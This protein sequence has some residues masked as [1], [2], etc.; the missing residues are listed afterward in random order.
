MGEIESLKP[1][2]YERVRASLPILTVWALSLVFSLFVYQTVLFSALFITALVT[3]IF[4]FMLPSM[5]YFRL[6][7]KS[8]F[9]SIP[10]CGILPNRLYM[11]ALQCLGIIFILGNFTGLSMTLYH[12]FQN[13]H[14]NMHM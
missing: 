14:T 13:N 2:T 5:L 11:H 8:D 6:G 12:N 10:I 4:M 1:S 9:E 3:S 7:V